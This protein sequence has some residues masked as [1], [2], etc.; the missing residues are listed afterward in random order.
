MKEVKA[1]RE[2]LEKRMKSLASEIDDRLGAEEWATDGLPV[3]RDT[4]FFNPPL[5]ANDHN[6][7]GY[8]FRRGSQSPST[9]V[10]ADVDGQSEDSLR[11]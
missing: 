8:K 2:D 6:Y 5:L 1:I 10:A 7:T 4:S 3:V 9:R 11:R